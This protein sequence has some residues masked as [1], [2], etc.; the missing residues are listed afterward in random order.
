[1]RVLT[2]LLADDEQ[3]NE[4]KGFLLKQIAALAP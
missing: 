3:F 4:E 1:L 2:Q